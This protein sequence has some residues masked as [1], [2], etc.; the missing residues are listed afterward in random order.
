MA[1]WQFWALLSAVFA[2]LTAVFAKVGIAGV[3]PD[4][5]TLIRTVVIL[6][7]LGALVAAMGEG[8]GLRHA[9]ART[10]TF[11]VLSGLATG[12]SWWCYFRALQLGDAA[13]VAPLDKLSVV[14]VALF[15]VGFLGER[16]APMNW[17]GILMMAAGAW[18]VTLR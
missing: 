9:S 12:A 5:A 15:G 6:I 17:A 3:H 10:W 1:S 11:L 8:S 7:V 18:L 2:A 16:L 14:L 4:V 13:R